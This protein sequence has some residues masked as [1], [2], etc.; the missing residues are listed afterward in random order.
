MQGGM[1]AVCLFR[2]CSRPGRRLTTQSSAQTDILLS[3]A[4]PSPTV[5]NPGMHTIESVLISALVNAQCVPKPCAT[6]DR[7]WLKLQRCART[8]KGVSALGQLVSLCLWKSP[9]DLVEKI[10]SHLPSDIRILGMKQ[11]TRGF[12]SKTMCEGRKY[13]YTLPTFAL[14]GGTEPDSSFRL[15]RED[16]HR[17]H[18]LLTFYQGTHCYHNFTLGKTAD[19]P[20]AFRHIF[21]VTLREPYVDK[22]HEFVTIEMTG[23][24]FLLNQIR[25]M[26]GLALSVTQG[27]VPESTL[28]SSVRPEISLKIPPA[29]GLGLVLE[30]TYFNWYNLRFGEDGLH[31]PLIWE[32]AEPAAETFRKNHILPLIAHGEIDDLSMARWLRTLSK[33]GLG[34]F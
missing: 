16:F 13:S 21:R 7:A 20:S 9:D 22:G 3:Y 4:V 10:N 25:K 23:Q 24:S 17:F 5:I 34:A 18:N 14:S 26:V 33:H 15:S 19:D 28:P 29:P 6:T 2:I 11:V 8:D 31:S 1:R 12:N 27:L 30:Q 32:D